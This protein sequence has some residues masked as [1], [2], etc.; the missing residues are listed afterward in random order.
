[1]VQIIIASHGGMAAGIKQSSEMIFG[2]QPNI[3]TVTFLP[4]EGLEDLTAKYNQVINTFAA[5][6]EILFLIDLWGGSPFNVASSIQATGSHKSAIVTGLNLPMVIEAAGVQTTMTD[7]EEMAHYL[8]GIA[9]EGIRSLPEVVSNVE[10]ADVPQ[11]IVHAA[12]VQRAATHT[13]H[14]EL[15]VRLVRIDSRLLHGQ[16]ATGWTKSAGQERIFVVSDT[17]AQD[18]MRKTLITQAA[19]ANVTASVIPIAKLIDIYDDTRFHG[20]KVMMLFETPQDVKRVTDAGIIFTS[21]NV[22]SMTYTDGKTMITNAV[23][24]D[25]DDVADFNSMMAAGVRFEVR[26]TPRDSEQD[27]TTLFKKKKLV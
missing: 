27:L 13:G 22:G 24:V 9:K 23:A 19:P 4:A 15:D 18:E 11:A 21:V 14:M 1:M 26:Q 17:V 5:T 3:N 8:V 20:V 25:A 7:I 2:V 16:V 12:P 6:D 10:P